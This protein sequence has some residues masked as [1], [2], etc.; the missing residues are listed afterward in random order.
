M[1]GRMRQS[2]DWVGVPKQTE[3]A[4]VKREARP[5]REMELAKVPGRVSV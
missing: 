5:K 1:Q 3:A 4:G 2:N